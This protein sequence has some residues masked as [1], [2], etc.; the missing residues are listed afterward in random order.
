MGT[1]DQVRRE[2]IQRAITGEPTTSRHVQLQDMG[3][4][5]V[6]AVFVNPASTPSS[7]GEQTAALNAGL[8][9]FHN[10]TDKAQFDTIQ[11]VKP[12]VQYH[13]YNA[14]FARGIRFK[15][16]M[17]PYD[18]IRVRRAIHLAIDR[19]EMLETLTFGV[20]GINQFTTS[21]VTEWT[22]PKAELMKMPGYRQPKDQ[23]I[24][25]ARRLLTEAG[26]ANGFKANLFFYSAFT[27]HPS[28]GEMVAGQLKRIGVEAS[29][30]GM[31]RATGAEANRQGAYEMTL[32]SNG[33]SE[34]PD[35]GLRSTWSSK[36]SVG[37]SSGLADPELDRLID[38]QGIEMDPAKRVEILQ[39]L[40]QL[41][42]DRV[43]FVPL[44][45]GG[46]FTVWQPYLHN[47]DLNFSGTPRLDRPADAWLDVNRMPQNRR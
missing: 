33:M 42:M 35:A 16:N 9:D 34:A 2:A 44:V 11:A 15:I 22:V 23:D 7:L 18:D 5:L 45:S 41:M 29:L 8:V 4:G 6:D 3:D 28:L 10:V 40:N 30:K 20:G 13:S 32:F 25:E 31:E 37:R 19:Q 43:Y 27:D 26:Y 46:Y 21:V 24:A 1:V 47:Y 14:G 17:A 12:D 36:G 39:K 38:E